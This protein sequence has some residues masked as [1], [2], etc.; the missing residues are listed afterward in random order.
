MKVSKNKKLSK[1]NLKFFD[2]VFKITSQIPYGKVTTYGHIAEFCGLKSSART[3]GWALNDAKDTGL[4]CHR[5][6]NRFGALTGKLHF[7]D[8]KLME[9]MLRAEGIEF[10]DK[11]CVVLEKHLWV[12]QKG[13]NKSKKEK[14]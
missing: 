13:K 11:N 7:G 2:L 1:S 6:V 10:N 8:P 5:V 4:P 14:R 9:E 3:V 12:P